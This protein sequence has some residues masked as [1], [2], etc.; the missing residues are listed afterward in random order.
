M[1]KDYVYITDG[2]AVFHERRDCHGI[3]NAHLG[4][5]YDKNRDT[6]VHEVTREDAQAKGRRRC[7]LPG[8]DKLGPGSR[9]QHQRGRYGTGAI[10]ATVKPGTE[11]MHGMRAG[12]GYGCHRG[13]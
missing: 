5:N 4:L 11:C 9:S 13:T 12:C 6:E 1:M 10:P 8:C 2:G 3:A 7:E